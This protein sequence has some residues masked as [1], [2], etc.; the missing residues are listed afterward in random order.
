MLAPVFLHFIYFIL[1]SS[2]DEESPVLIPRVKA[3]VSASMEELRGL[4]IIDN[5]AR[6]EDLNT[7]SEGASG[8]KI[9]G[10]DVKPS[11]KV[12]KKN[13]KKATKTPDINK[14]VK[15]TRQV[16]N[17]KRP[18]PNPFTSEEDKILLEAISSGE[19][20]DFTKLAKMM[21]R[22]RKSVKHRVEKLKLSGGVSTKTCPRYNLQED[23]TILD[24]AVEN[25]KKFAKL[26]DTPLKHAEDLAASFRRKTESVKARW[27][28]SLKVWL[29][30][31]YTKT[32]NLNIKVMLANLLADNFEDIESI[33][34]NFV[35]SF[36]EFDGHTLAS[37]RK[38]FSNIYKT[39]KDHSK[40]DKTKLTLKEIA[41][42][43]AV[44]YSQ[45]NARKIPASTLKRQR[46]VIDYFEK[47]V[48]DLGIKDFL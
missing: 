34:W 41:E 20:L 1:D 29:K 3:L 24:S 35:K 12:S 11:K 22:D 15:K 46:E 39:A 28:T 6:G 16:L 19:E 26:D 36:K 38:S 7:T 9:V 47:K 44:T 43:A 18:A 13:T 23:L 31:F 8:E 33:D 14:S 10:G 4:D 45:E 32:L 37:I 5:R 48:K 2:S 17:R 40:E 27:E 42:D 30:S 21:N 25:L